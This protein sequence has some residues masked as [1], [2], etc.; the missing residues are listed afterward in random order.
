MHI[1]AAFSTINQKTEIKLPPSYFL[2]PTC[3]K[4]LTTTLIYAI[5][6][7]TIYQ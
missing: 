1:P 5:I 2:L 7:K 4:S 3:K 6:A